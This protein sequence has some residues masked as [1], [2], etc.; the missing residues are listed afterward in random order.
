MMIQIRR[1]L[2]LWLAGGMPVIINVHTKDRNSTIYDG[3]N[4]MIANCTI[5]GPGGPGIEIYATGERLD[6]T[7]SFPD[8]ELGNHPK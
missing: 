2:I 4:A 6:N 5:D 8:D 1:K 7:L 3:Q